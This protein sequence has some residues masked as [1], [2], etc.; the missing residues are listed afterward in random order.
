MRES[1][2]VN[3]SPFSTMTHCRGKLNDSSNASFYTLK[4]DVHIKLITQDF[5]SS[6]GI[7]EIL[8]TRSYIIGELKNIV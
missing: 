8:A 6:D 5:K 7:L 1:I 3:N 2:S 4:N